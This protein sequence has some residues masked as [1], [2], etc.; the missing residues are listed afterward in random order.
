[1]PKII[2]GGA[3]NTPDMETHKLP[4]GTFGFSA[5]RLDA[6][7]A[8]EYTLAT[9]VVDVSGSVEPYKRD[10]EGALREIVNALKLSPRADNLM[11]RIVG[12]NT[13]LY[14]I[15]GYK[16][17]G[18]CNLDDYRDCLSPGGM[19][20]LFDAS[21]NA[22]EATTVYAKTLSANDFAVNGIVVVMTD[23]ADNASKGYAMDVQ[24]VLQAATKSEALEFLVF[25]LIGVGMKAEP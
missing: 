8:T 16:L 22:V 21:E 19:T 15:H 24:K 12:F 6:L 9:V 10:L 14:E 13:T 1:M 4:T 3:L 20:A 5:T 25:I 23:G 7:G 11:V 2:T 18:A 17:L